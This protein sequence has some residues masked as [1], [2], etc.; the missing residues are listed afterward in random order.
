MMHKHDLLHFT[1]VYFFGGGIRDASS[2]IIIYFYYWYVLFNLW[3]LHSYHCKW[4][5]FEFGRND[6]TLFRNVKSFELFAFGRQSIIP[7]C[8]SFG[9]GY[10]LV[11][12]FSCRIF[13][14]IFETVSMLPSNIACI[15]LCNYQEFNQWLN[16]EHVKTCICFVIV[17]LYLYFMCISL[18]FTIWLLE[19]LW[20][21]ETRKQSATSLMFAHSLDISI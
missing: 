20:T 11:L 9:G 14:I 12:R 4:I 17:R 8:R 5:A 2:P 19:P 18:L 10:G 1:M 16:I 15:R 13:S 3:G 7:F 6:Y 21:N